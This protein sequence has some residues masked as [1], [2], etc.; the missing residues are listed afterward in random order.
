MDNSSDSIN[1][2]KVKINGEYYYLKG[3]APAEHIEKLAAYVDEK[4]TFVGENY[5]R[6]ST[7]NVTILAALL[8]TEDLF[9]LKQEYEEFL[10]TFDAKR[11]DL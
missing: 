9:Q 7:V 8:I 4:V 2:V 6:L 1:R 11:K 3:T 10:D 5:P